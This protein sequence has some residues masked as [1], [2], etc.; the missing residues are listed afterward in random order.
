MADDSDDG[1][2][3]LEFEVRHA[4]I[5]TFVV[6]LFAGGFFMSAVNAVTGPTGA[7]VQNGD[8]Q[9]TQ[10]SDTGDNNP[11]PSPS[12]QQ[13]TDTIDMSKISMEGEPVLGQSDAPVTI[14][15]YEDFQCP[16]CK[17]FET[18]AMPKIVSNYVETGKAKVVWKDF[19]LPQLH[20]WA[21]SA[22]A[23]MECVYRQN[24]DAFWA[25]REKVF[26]NQDT[27][28]TGNVE[29]KIKQWAAA[30]GV[31]KSAVQ[32][33]LD[34]GNPMQEVDE[35]KQEGSSL[36]VSGTPTVFINGKKVVGAQPYSR[37]KSI[38]ESE[39]SG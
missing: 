31:S 2:V 5:L 4:L 12:G 3:T 35:D 26:A 16:F 39:L 1:M 14:V 18:N 17:R 9:P 24:N 36:G 25:V 7:I 13:G 33:C 6:G 28:T 8:Q 32:S 20:P 21:K 27:I 29:S 30:E 23:A 15:A 10:P 22:A 11:S 34:N 38:I 37:F 19:P